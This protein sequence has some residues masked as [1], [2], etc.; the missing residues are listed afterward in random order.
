[1]SNKLPVNNLKECEQRYEQLYGKKS[2]TRET[3]RR[4]TDN[5]AVFKFVDARRLSQLVAEFVTPYVNGSYV[6]NKSRKD[7]AKPV[8]A[9]VT[10]RNDGS[11]DSGDDDHTFVRPKAFGSSVHLAAKSPVKLAPAVQPP[12]RFNGHH[13]SPNKQRKTSWSEK[14]YVPETEFPSSPDF[15]FSDDDAAENKDPD[16]ISI[17]SLSPPP[18]DLIVDSDDEPAVF[19]GVVPTLKGTV[20]LSPL[21]NRRAGEATSSAEPR[22]TLSI[23]EIC[24]IESSPLLS[25]PRFQ[26]GD[27]AKWAAIR[28]R[29]YDY[30]LSSHICTRLY[31]SRQVSASI[32]SLLE[33][34]L[35]VF[36]QLRKATLCTTNS[37]S[38][39]LNKTKSSC[40]FDGSRGQSA[41]VV[42][43]D[44]PKWSP[45]VADDS[46]SRSSAT[47][48]SDDRRK[49]SPASVDNSPLDVPLSHRLKKLAEK[50][51]Q[52]GPS[53]S[54]HSPEPTPEQPSTSKNSPYF[55]PNPSTNSAGPPMNDTE[56][57]QDVVTQDDFADPADDVASEPRANF[58][59]DLGSAGRFLGKY[60]ND[61]ESATFKGF[62]FPH[63]A[64]MRAKFGSVFGLKQFRLNQLEAINA[65][66]LGED[67]FI[68]MPTGGGKSLCYQLPAVVSE[69]VT[70][71]ISPLK[72]LIYDQVQKLGSLDVPANHLSGDSDDFSVYS[73]LRSAQPSL[74]LL[75]VTPEKVSASGR[76]LDALS[77]LHA[78][79]RLS[80]FVI[81]EAHCVS[82][83]GHDFRPDYKKLSVLREKF[84]GVPMMALTATATPRVRTDILH[85]LGMRDPKWFLQSFNRPNLRYEIRLKSGKVGTARE[86]LE[87]VE[88]KFAR[89]S[90]I[91]YCFSR[92]E[93]DD[94]AE[95][96]SKNGV[97]A[98]AYHA[99]LDDPKRNAVQQRWIDDKVRVVCAT[100]A[101]GMGVDKPDVRF[102]VHY[103][104]PKSMEGFYQESGR[105]G[106]DGRPA[107]CLLFYSFADVQRIR[108]MVEM[109][110]ASNYA[111][112][113]THLSNLWH[114]VNFCENRTDCRRAQVLHYFG[115]NFDRTFC[116][117]NRRFA[118]DNCLS[119]GCWVM[120]DVTEDAR[121]VVRCVEELCQQRR[122]V[123]VNMVVDIFKGCTNKKMTKENFTNL[124]LHG[125]G[126]GYQRTD[127]DRL[128]R[129]LIL[130][131]YL[132]EESV[133]NYLEMAVSYVHPGS[134][135]A[136]LVSGSAK[137]SLAIQK[138]SRPS[139]SRS[140]AAEDAEPQEDPQVAK[141]VEACH[142]EL[143]SIAK[144]LA[145][146]KKTFYGNVIHM[147]ALRG[148][149]ETLPTT[150]EA[151]LQVPHMTRALVDKYGE[152]L[153]EVT[154]RYA[155]EKIVLEAERQ[156]E[157]QAEVNKAAEEEFQNPEPPSEFTSSNRGLKRK[158]GG[159]GGGHQ[160][161]QRKYPFKKKT[162]NNSF[163]GR[164]KFSGS[165]SKT[166]KKAAGKASAKSAKWTGGASTSAGFGALP[167]PKPQQS[168][169]FLGK[170]KVVEL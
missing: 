73:D 62:G 66:L 7:A 138:K 167:M 28:L 54:F 170:P 5:A 55:V 142:A 145:A 154:E 104:L 108:R 109:D 64:E 40:N 77:R 53:T 92:K 9:A 65:A 22:D 169:S 129:R 48:V 8:S 46:R 148:L 24:E 27:E 42:A 29:D 67:C 135:A 51:R 119:R 21:K 131:G 137:V 107:S 59:D 69:G 60:R 158:S 61:G 84:S 116:E 3:S 165:P 72:S 103:T 128:L 95:E 82:Q 168:R 38:T 152:Q 16:Y 150:T 114:M 33:L 153:L 102:V 35:K 94:L 160:K 45:S 47:S 17:P 75:Y 124:R 87:V 139:E 49:Q 111:A 13:K 34:R 134:K 63:S 146:E 133:I 4:G 159:A 164:G 115:E 100:I 120:K 14:A 132:K 19:E 85:Q 105:A 125:R 93:C 52:N 151:M 90:G 71:V 76:L 161:R 144:A 56:F 157:R 136:Q 97:P 25:K 130:E 74:R 41:A 127:A 12:P 79:G 122:K 126:K 32:I 1:M 166:R 89:Q 11:H 18:A 121:E 147:E 81:D 106:R 23:S 149:A 96:L 110:K 50:V 68:L 83:W 20:R 140:A 88:G 112:K 6:A 31:E 118:C 99:G 70:V 143:V 39:P 162:W 98:V 101:F 91:I 10:E 80:R 57:I 86:V 30:R 26:S 113:Q 123:T 155:A 36:Q 15:V 141:L 78:N 2:D 163:K 44:S 117:R 156:A 58:S 37:D 43:D